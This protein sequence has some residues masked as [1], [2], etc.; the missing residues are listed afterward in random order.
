M[1]LCERI[2]PEMIRLTNLTVKTSDTDRNELLFFPALMSYTQRP[3]MASKAL[4]ENVAI[5]DQPFQFGWCLQCTN[6]YQH[7][8]PRFLQLLILRLAFK[9]ALP[10]SQDNLHD[11]KCTM[12]STGIMWS[13]GYCVDT[14]VELVDE[15][16]CIILL[17][18]SEEGLQHNMIPVRR[19]VIT[20]I[21]SIQQECC[22]S[23]E[24]KELV[25][26]PSELQ[27]PIDKS[28]SLLLF[29]V[30]DIASSVLDKKPGVTSFS[31]SKGRFVDKS[32]KSLF[33]LEHDKGQDIS[34]FVGRSIEVR[35]TN[36][37]IL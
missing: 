16:K 29:D 35:D 2:T 22:P 8:S 14:L 7:L 20:D 21:L 37:C 34:I 13:S 15:S 12:W 1:K 11:R 28:L 31:E 18:S 30:E 3:M 9:H 32:L 10:K 23:V 25:F 5:I 24:P 26:H 19:A 27:Y 6:Q 4:E 36:R 33:P 17:M